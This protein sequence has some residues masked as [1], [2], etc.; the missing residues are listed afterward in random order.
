MRVFSVKRRNTQIL[1]DG[2][3]KP[4]NK[5]IKEKTLS[6]HPSRNVLRSASAVR[7][8]QWEEGVHESIKSAPSETPNTN[9]AV[10]SE[11]SHTLFLV[12]A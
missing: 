11:Q 5:I 6:L 9:S 12:I 7:V 3:T 8:S 1:K 10:A 2:R 4:I